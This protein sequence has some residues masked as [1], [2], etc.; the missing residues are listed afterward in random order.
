[1]QSPVDKAELD[2]KDE[3]MAIIKLAS[4]KQIIR[5]LPPEVLLHG[6]TAEER[7]R[8][9]STEQRLAGLNDGRTPARPGPS[10][11]LAARR[12]PSAR[13]P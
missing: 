6:L 5:S 9:L 12:C 4:T 1:M 13:W 2:N 3:W 11:A 8:G 7:V 10:R